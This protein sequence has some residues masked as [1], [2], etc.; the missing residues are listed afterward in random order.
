MPLYELEIY[1]YKA[2]LEVLGL[3]RKFMEISGTREGVFGEDR[4]TV[5]VWLLTDK[6]GLD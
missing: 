2:G 3:V 4:W 6:G 5:R 1:N